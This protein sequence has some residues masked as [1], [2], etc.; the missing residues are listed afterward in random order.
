V[1]QFRFELHERR[2][3]DAAMREPLRQW[4]VDLRDPERNRL[5]YDKV[6]R[7]YLFRLSID[8]LAELGERPHLRVFVLSIDGRQFTD[9]MEL[10]R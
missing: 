9:T 4:N 2:P 6:T 5:H 10:T 7:T 8:D 1:G 3:A